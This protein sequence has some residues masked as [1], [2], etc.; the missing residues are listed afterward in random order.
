MA[1]DEL[2]FLRTHLA[3]ERTALAY[4]R[5]ALAL[6]AAG[7]GLIHF[8]PTGSS[9]VAGSGLIGLGLVTLLVGGIRFVRMRGRIGK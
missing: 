5:T 8:I 2:S 3:N 4:L 1:R 7:A 6:V 9:L